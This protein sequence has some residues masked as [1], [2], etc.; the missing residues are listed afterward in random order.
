[1][2][3][4]LFAVGLAVLSAALVACGGGGGGNNN[5][6][7]S[8]PVPPS[9]TPTPTSSPTPATTSNPYGCVGQPPFTAAASTARRTSSIPHPIATGDTFSYGGSL[10]RVYAQSAPCPQPTATSSA[11]VTVSVSNSA[12]SSPSGATDVRSTE[13]DAFALQT[14][15]VTT[16]QIVENTSSAYELFSTKSADASGNSITT[17]YANPQTLDRLPETAG[18]SW[19][20]NPAASVSEALADGTSVSRTVNPNG[21]YSETLSYPNGVTNA[22]S[23]PDLSGAADYHLAPGQEC[24]GE[25]DFAYQAPSAGTISVVITGWNP[26]GSSC[27]STQFTRTFPQWFSTPVAAYATDSFADNGSKALDATCSVGISGITSGEQIVETSSVLDPALGY[28]D[29]RVTTSYVVS[30]YGAVCVTIADTLSS[31]YDYSDDTTKIDYQSQ[32]GQPNSVDTIAETLSMKSAAC[33]SGSAPCTAA[34]TSQSVSGVSP[35]A[36]AM[37]VAAIEHLREVQRTQRIEQMR[38]FARQ[39]TAHGGLR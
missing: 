30:G 13:S 1:M 28:T 27:A 21:T 8:T 15:T 22:V 34:R 14:T 35:L 19:S 4:R 26:S 25:V 38:T 36:V 5:Y 11:A 2:K 16:D 20:N 3:T 31:Y 39:F 17:T 6:T 23:V 33:S 9:P 29:K 32:N 7:P 24:N 18:A 12:A 37:H 10:N